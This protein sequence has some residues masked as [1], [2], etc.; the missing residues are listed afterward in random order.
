MKNQKMKEATQHSLIT[1]ENILKQWKNLSNKQKSEINS[2]IN[3][4]KSV[5]KLANEGV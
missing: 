1:F 4:L 2:N 5:L 3:Y